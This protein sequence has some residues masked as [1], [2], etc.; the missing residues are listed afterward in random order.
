MTIDAPLL[1]NIVDA[2]ASTADEVTL[3]F[4]SNGLKCNAY[5]AVRIAGVFLKCNAESFSEYQID[6]DVN[7]T[8]SLQE[9]VKRLRFIDKKDKITIEL[10]EEG[11]IKMTKKG[12]YT[13]TYIVKTLNPTEPVTKVPMVRYST[14]VKIN[15]QSLSKA[16][17]ETAIVSDEVNVKVTPNDVAIEA[18][19]T[20]GD[21]V[22]CFARGE[23]PLR[24]ISSES[25]VEGTYSL[26][27]FKDIIKGCSGITDIVTLELG[28][29]M[30]LHI[31]F[32]VVWGKLEY[33]LAP[34][35]R[36]RY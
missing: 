2:I 6:N 27:F 24:F 10:T 31:E 30:P 4:T 32:G 17:D 7:L 20:L 34:K 14:Q 22:P 21:V 12:A 13:T 33:Y 5:D 36:E 1:K 25:E 29:N 3:Q 11:Y 35:L 9:F 15:Y 18:K 19:G 16:I 26:I 23:S 8:V 28:T